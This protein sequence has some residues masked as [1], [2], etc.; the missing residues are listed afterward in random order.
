MLKFHID[1]AEEAAKTLRANFLEAN[2][3]AVIYSISLTRSLS[4]SLT[5]VLH[6][7]PPFFFATLCT[8]PVALCWSPDSQFQ[9]HVCHGSL[10]KSGPV[11]TIKC[12]VCFH[13]PLSPPAKSQV[14]M[15]AAFP[16]QA[17][18]KCVGVTETPANNNVALAAYQ[19]WN[20]KACFTS[21][22]A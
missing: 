20:L 4:D 2:L 8:H 11:T 22:S 15:H 5:Y 14:G 16:K 21:C 3:K 6:P 7:A 12:A 13:K 19:L 18:I 10:S 1:L 9:Q 17:A